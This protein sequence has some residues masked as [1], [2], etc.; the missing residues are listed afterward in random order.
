MRTIFV[1]IAILVFAG[2]ESTVAGFWTNAASFR[3]DNGSFV[4]LAAD[5]NSAGPDQ[6]LVLTRAGLGPL[7]AN[8]PFD[9]AAIRAAFPS[10][11]VE[12]RDNQS[13][14]MNRP[15][16]DVFKSG[17]EIIEVR[18][19][20]GKVGDISVLSR[21]IHDENGIRVGTKYRDFPQSAIG[22]C[23]FGAEELGDKVVCTTTFSEG[24]FYW[25][26]NHGLNQLDTQ[27]K[28]IA[29]RIAPNAEVWQVRWLSAA[30]TGN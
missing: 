12:L 30:S 7:G 14:G 22:S 21:E 24:I 11:D 15:E 5:G 1:C 6:D 27:A 26:T 19:E 13:E 4:D 18:G 28:D 10:Y 9:L 3:A 20:A 17:V 25:F 29:K 2:A 23:E 16:I 8:S